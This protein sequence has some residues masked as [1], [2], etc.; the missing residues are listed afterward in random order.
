MTAFKQI[1]YSDTGALDAFSRLRTSTPETTF[2][3]QNQYDASPLEMEGGASGTGVA[4]LFS[5]NN[6]MV[7]LSGT[8][9][10]GVSYYQSYQYMSY[11]PGKSQFIAITGVLGTGV[12][13]WTKDFGYFD[14][15][16]GVIY[17]QNGA[18]DLRVGIRSST[19]GGV[20]ENWISQANWNIDGMNINLN[21][22]N[23]S[24]MTL[25]P[26]KAFI[27]LI[28]LQFL[29]MG[30]VRVGFDIDG[31]VY[32]V[33][34]FLHANI[35][36]VPYMQSA[37]L[38]VGALLTGTTTAAPTNCYFKC[39][40]VQ[41]EGGLLGSFGHQFSTPAFNITAAA[42]RTHLMTVRP[43]TL[44][45]AMPN[46]SLFSFDQLNITATGNNTIFWELCVG[47][48]LTGASVWT[49]VNAT[50]SA[51]EYNTNGVF[52]IASTPIVISSGF[53]AATNTTKTSMDR[54]VSMHYPITLTR[55]GANRDLGQLTLL[56]TSLANTTV[57]YASM[58]HYEIR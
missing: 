8:A 30:R 32:Y 42:T 15:L 16:N 25:D 11:Q 17:R 56:V 18:T 3:I 53:I 41:S 34:E 7:Q 52:N 43:K 54:N 22:K 26:N 37:T 45:N 58:E 51:F 40:T 48:N 20:V 27:L 21:T 36:T 55:A 38:P 1:S 31:V 24:G 46:R 29:G 19:S 57:T 9:G 10:T 23:P 49:S 2:Q 33:H 44:F 6:R 35:L 13:G 12:A 47:A 28:D 4:P 50:H 5:V 14:S 39:A